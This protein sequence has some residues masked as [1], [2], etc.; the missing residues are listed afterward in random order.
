M[1]RIAN[2][3]GM[4]CVQFADVYS[5][6]DV[7]SS[8]D[9]RRARPLPSPVPR[10]HSLDAHPYKHPEPLFAA[11][12]S[13]YN[14]LPEMVAESTEAIV[15]SHSDRVTLDVVSSPLN[16]IIQSC[17]VSNGC[18]F[19]SGELMSSDILIRLSTLENQLVHT[20]EKVKMR[21]H[22]I[23]QL[24]EEIQAKERLIYEQGHLIHILENENKLDEQAMQKDFM[25]SQRQRLDSETADSIPSDSEITII[26]RF[27]SS[28][29]PCHSN[30]NYS[31]HCDRLRERLEQALI[32]RE[33]LELQN[34]QLLKQWEEALEYVTTV[35][36]QLQEEIRRNT[37]L[38]TAQMEAQKS[39]HDTI[40]ISRGTLNFVVLLAVLIGFYLYRI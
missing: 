33:K 25:G 34:E 15:D 23:E 21:E 35:Q 27:A 6:G 22:V 30:S 24:E 26:D 11:R 9:R 40:T 17:A 8:G 2:S 36:K 37:E 1:R 3:F 7:D 39:N 16:P 29:S 14:P 32:E 10:C 13:S 18:S 20:N 12:R 31:D 28:S 38:K 4:F 19:L 5:A